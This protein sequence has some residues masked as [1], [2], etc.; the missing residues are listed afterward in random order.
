MPRWPLLG[1][2]LFAFG[3]AITEGAMADWSAVYLR[4]LLDAHGGAVG[5]GYTLLAA[6]IAAGRFGSDRS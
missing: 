3:I 2:A 5:V 6:M 4:E 1:I